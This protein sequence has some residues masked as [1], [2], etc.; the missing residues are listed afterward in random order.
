MWKLETYGVMYVAGAYSFA[1][2]YIRL[3][4]SAHRV[5][6][7][8]LGL[9]KAK[10]CL[11]HPQEVGAETWREV[12]AAEFAGIVTTCCRVDET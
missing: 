7:R 9:R 10:P 12:E 1:I 8:Q 4:I 2:S 3:R 5:R 11:T 6:Q